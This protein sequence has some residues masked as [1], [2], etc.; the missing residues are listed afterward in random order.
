MLHDIRIRNLGV[1][2]EATAEFAEGLTAVTGETGA[3]KTMVVS[4]LRLLSGHRANASTVRVGADKAIIEGIFSAPT[5]AH[6]AAENIEAIISDFGGFADDGEYIASRTVTASGRSRAHLAGKTVAAGVLSQFANQV[7]TIHG[8]NDQLRLQDSTRQLEALDQFAGLED[9]V[10]EFVSLRRAWLASKKDLEQRTAARR[11]LALETD[12]LQRAIATIDEIDPQPH[13]DEELKERITRLQDADDLR[14]AMQHAMTAIDGAVDASGEGDLTAGAN[15]LLGQA[16]SAL[17]VKDEQLHNI[18]QRIGELISQLSDISMEIGNALVDVPDPDEL[19]DMLQRQQQLRELRRFAVDV[20]GALAWRDEA[21]ERLASINVSGEALEELKEKID[22]Q[23][24]HMMRVGKELSTARQSAAKKFATAVTKEIKG[25]HMSAKVDVA[26][27]QG[28]PNARGLDECEFQMV[29]G[30]HCTALA[31]SASGGELSRVMLALEVI[32]AGHGRTMVFDEVDA[33]VG[34]KAAVEIG[35]RLATLAK[36]NQVIVV[37]HLPQVAAFADAH[38]YVDKSATETTVSSSVRSLSP[39]ERVAEL[40]RM[41]AGLESDSGRAHAE[42]LLAMAE[43][44]K[45]EN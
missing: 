4:S 44:A 21:R 34:G 20:D 3:G 12:T 9:K 36:H 17:N 32:L 2:E 39:T 40:S 38:V 26:L 30:G 13:E 27:T 23:H 18:G 29:Q 35:R 19:Q 7:L 6:S 16:Q 11:E 42:E 31:S 15:D 10:S 5:D 45:A 14:S 25:L 43:E 41:L 33:G 28:Q 24:D 37:T 22:E 8:Q 1:I